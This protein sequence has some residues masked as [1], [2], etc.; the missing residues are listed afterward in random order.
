MPD[1]EARKCRFCDLVWGTVG[2]TAGFIL[3]YMGVDLLTSGGL[4]RMISGGFAA[5]SQEG[6]E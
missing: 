6:D 3:L 5:T 1:K 2:V 4:S